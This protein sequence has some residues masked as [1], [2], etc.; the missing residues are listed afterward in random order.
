MGRG[1]SPWPQTLPRAARAP[2]PVP[3]A[4]C[5]TPGTVG[6]PHRDC[7][8]ATQGLLLW[9][10]STIGPLQCGNSTMWPVETG[11]SRLRQ[12]RWRPGS[13]ENEEIG[14]ECG[15][16]ATARADTLH[17]RSH[18][19]QDASGTPNG[20]FSRKIRGKMA[21]PGVWGPGPMGAHGAPIH[22]G[23][24]LRCGVAAPLHVTLVLLLKS[25]ARRRRRY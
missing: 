13:P 2:C 21:R 22:P 23:L 17:A 3:R 25:A 8:A 15:R 6:N 18:G 24:A 11:Y 5:R 16:A 10:N 19:P 7:V 20:P 14:H 9:Y 12:A 4:P 1:R